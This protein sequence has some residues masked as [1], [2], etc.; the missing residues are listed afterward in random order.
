[1][2]RF[3]RGIVPI[4]IL[5]FGHFNVL[6]LNAWQVHCGSPKLLEFQNVCHQMHYTILRS[7]MLQSRTGHQLA[8]PPCVMLLYTVFVIPQHVGMCL[9]ALPCLCI[10]LDPHRRTYLT[11]SS[12]AFDKFETLPNTTNQGLVPFSTSFYLAA[13][14]FFLSVLDIWLF[15]LFFV[16][17]YNTYIVR[18]LVV[19]M[20]A[21][22]N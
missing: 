14:M 7:H 13:L 21:G 2:W 8:I 3:N 6:Y 15:L 16:S 20:G 11:V 5:L 4:C 9:G 1:M 19:V 22:H 10:T 17:L 18:C 12:N